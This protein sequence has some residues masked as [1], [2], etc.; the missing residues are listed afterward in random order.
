MSCNVSVCSSG[1]LLVMAEEHC[2][3]VYSLLDTKRPCSGCLTD[4][5]MVSYAG[6]RSYRISKLNSWFVTPAWGT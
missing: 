2:S 1:M 5:S 4:F 3:I 6:I